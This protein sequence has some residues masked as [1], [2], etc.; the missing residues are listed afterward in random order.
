MN[1]DALRQRCEEAA[2]KCLKLL[3]G[4]DDTKAMHVAA[5]NG[6][7]YIIQELVNALEKERENQP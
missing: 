4:Y 6:F 3:G 5:L 1:H 7:T 2:L